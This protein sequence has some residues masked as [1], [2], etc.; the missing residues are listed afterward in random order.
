MPE[1]PEVEVIARF[2]VQTAAGRSIGNVAVYRRDLRMRIADDFERIV[3]GCEI[4][5]VGRVSRYLV[6]TLN[7][8]GWHIVFHLGMSGRITWSALYT[9]ET[10]DHVVFTLD[11]GGHIVFNDARRFGAVLLVSD[12]QYAALRK[13]IGP[14]PLSK[15]FCA[16]HLHKVRSKSC[17][18]AVLMNNSLVAGIGN[19]YASEIL[20]RAGVSP[21]RPVNSLSLE[22]CERVVQ[23]AKSTLKLAIDAGGSTIKDYRMPTG[24][25]GGFQEHFAVY[26]RNGQP[27]RTCGSPILV[28]KRGGRSTFFCARCQR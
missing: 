5:S 15:E 9:P 25:S 10:H 1:L 22:E 11:N 28:I 18:K 2:F 4:R 19:I 13:G 20:F 21:M 7:A 12:A 16:E 23:K 8:H 3:V 14:E 26:G 24:V 6:F 27:C 17:I